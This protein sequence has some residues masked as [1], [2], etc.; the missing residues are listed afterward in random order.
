[1]NIIIKAE[2]LR[3]ILPK[4]YIMLERYYQEEQ[5]KNFDSCFK[6]MK[7]VCFKNENKEYE[8]ALV[9][10]VKKKQ[11]QEQEQEQEKEIEHL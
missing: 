7:L 10:E 5:S 6:D 4:L 9:E 2:Q 1:M 11:E 8:L 3:K